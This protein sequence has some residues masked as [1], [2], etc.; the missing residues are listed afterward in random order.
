MVC[1]AVVGLAGVCLAVVCCCVV[2]CC[3]VWATQFDEEPFAEAF[4][5]N[6]ILELEALKLILGLTGSGFGGLVW[7]RE[8]IEQCAPSAIQSIKGSWV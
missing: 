4:G 6:A 7:D 1:G 8:L 3:V 2:L 5:K